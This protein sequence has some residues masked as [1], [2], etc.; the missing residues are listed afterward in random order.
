MEQRTYLGFSE[1]AGFYRLSY[2]EWGD[3]HNPDVLL[4]VPALNRNGRDF[5]FLAGRLSDRYRV[6][7][8]DLV[9]RGQSDWFDDGASYSNNQYCHDINTLIAHLGVDHVDYLGASMGGMLGIFL[10]AQKKTP[11]RRLIL[12]DVGPILPHDSVE[13]IRRHALKENFFHTLDEADRFIRRIY[14]TFGIEDDNHWQ[15]LV[16]HSI[17]PKGDGYT[18]AFDPRA[19]RAV[20]WHLHLELGYWAEWN[21]LTCPILVLHGGE[22]DILTDGI[23]Q[24]MKESPIPFD[25]HT[26]EGCGHV[27][28]LMAD[29]H[30]DVVDRWLTQTTNRP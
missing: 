19:A 28:N 4:C 3:R 7:C 18:L 21:R 15:H 14:K 17:M 5:D 10:A 24:H 13:R 20:R 6:I 29:H 9:G 22:S 25:C 12:N 30:L 27:P 16:R 8:L 1:K 11:I 2:T 23:L 26:F